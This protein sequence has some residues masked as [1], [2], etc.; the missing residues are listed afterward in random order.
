MVKCDCVYGSIEQSCFN[1]CL[2]P[3]YTV[4]YIQT[5]SIKKIELDAF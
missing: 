1:T 3:G 2:N 5:R 4:E